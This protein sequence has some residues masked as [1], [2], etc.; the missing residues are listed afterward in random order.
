MTFAELLE[1]VLRIT[2][3]PLL[4]LANAFFV[5]IEF[6]LVTCRP[7]RIRE[8]VDKGVPRAGLLL[9]AASDRDRV[10]A[11]TQVGITITSLALGWVGEPILA[12]F[13]L[14]NLE[15][16]FGPT[17]AQLASHGT[18]VVV[19]FGLIT[20]LHVLIGEQVPKS[21]ALQRPAETGLVLAGP[22]LL[23]ERIFRP[24]I[25]IL[26]A[27]GNLI[28]RMIGL[29]PIPSIQR[30]HSADELKMIVSASQQ[31]GALFPEQGDIVR[32]ALDLPVRRVADIMI[33]REKI[34]ALD[35]H[36]PQDRLLEF[37]AEQGYTRMP[38]FDGSLDRIV[39]IVHSKDLFTITASKG[40]IILEDLM[41]E[42]YFVSPDLEVSEILHGFRSNRVHLAI[43]RDPQNR[44]IGLVTLEDV[45]EQ[46]VGH[47]AD[48]HDTVWGMGL[49][50]GPAGA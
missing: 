2:A 12:Q 33:P 6:G 15:R 7:T 42:P 19:A 3:I 43:V 18:A 9:R 13:F 21:I 27:A 30:V 48:E 37:V 36:T 25:W 34:V 40:L 46:L 23:C 1:M 4:L 39:G 24:F 10:I 11:A 16:V 41:R 14:T 45:L 26:Y 29:K 49:E 47:I 22:Y 35:V 38:V 32:R 28:I 44:I 8:L 5:A 31:G 50:P 17:A 20:F